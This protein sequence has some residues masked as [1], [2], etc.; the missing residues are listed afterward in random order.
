MSWE[1]I[2]NDISS[3]DLKIHPV[4][5]NVQIPVPERDISEIEIPGRD[6]VLHIDNKR[7]KPI[8]I[9][10]PLNFKYSLER[11]DE[12]KKWL[13][14]KGILSLTYEDDRFYKCNK[15]TFG[16]PQ[17]KLGICNITVTFECDPFSYSYMGTYEIYNPTSLYN[18]G[19][20]TKPI[21]RVEGEGI[22]ELS[23]NGNTITINVGQ[24]IVIDTELLI[25]YREDKVTAMSTI[26]GDI[27]KLYLNEGE[28]ELKI[29]EGFNLY[30]IPNWRYL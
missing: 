10:I 12:L 29:T 13:R 3:N 2:Y 14:G 20:E 22:C 18:T 26:T 1:L 19:Y 28:N 7:Y 25:A 9:P 11:F 8:L 23:V 17:I 24:S 21:Y 4:E 30:V 5:K 27:Q 15:I 6:G 16:T